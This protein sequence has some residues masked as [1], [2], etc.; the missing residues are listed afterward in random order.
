METQGIETIKQGLLAVVKLANTTDAALED[1]KISP[2]EWGKIGLAGFAL[3]RSIAKFKQMKLEWKDLSDDE[4]AE[5][6]AAFAEEFD[7][8]NDEAEK[9]I[10][11]G[12]AALLQISGLI[13]NKVA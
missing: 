13:F 7:L 10:E 6:I 1:G 3:A 11:E 8:R 4:R 12:F 2:V 9:M 5:I